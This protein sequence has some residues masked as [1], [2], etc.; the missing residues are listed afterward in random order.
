[1]MAALPL[2][3]L[4]VFMCMMHA[5]AQKNLTKIGYYDYFPLES[6]PIMYNGQLLMFE[7]IV[8]GSDPPANVGLGWNPPCKTYLRVRDMTTG[9][10]LQNITNSCNIAFG[11]AVTDKTEGMLDKLYVFGTEWARE[12]MSGPC[13]D[14]STMLCLGVIIGYYQQLAHWR[15]CLQNNCSVRAFYTTDPNLQAWTDAGVAGHP[16]YLVYNADVARV[17]AGSAPP[18]G[19]PSHQ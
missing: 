17:P 12:S 18:P 9:V 2:G 10:V 13:R 16:G 5:V 3:M 11:F 1:M 8:V 14:V 15:C 4:F 19:V 6:T 7:S